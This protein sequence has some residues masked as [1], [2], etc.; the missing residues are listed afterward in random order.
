LRFKAFDFCV[1]SR[2]AGVALFQRIENQRSK[3]KFRSLKAYICATKLE[4]GDLTSA[5]DRRGNSSFN[6]RQKLLASSQ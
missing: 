4:K 5:A 2:V 1:R 6:V 3:N